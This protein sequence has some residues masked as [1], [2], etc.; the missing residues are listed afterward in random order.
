M[1]VQQWRIRRKQ[2]AGLDLLLLGPANQVQAQILAGT[3][4]SHVVLQVRV[5][6]LVAWLEFRR[7]RDQQNVHLGWR[8]PAGGRQV[9]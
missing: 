8:Q 7:E 1:E 5:K 4:A 2:L 6:R 3:F 9:R